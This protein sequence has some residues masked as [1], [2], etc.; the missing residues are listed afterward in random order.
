MRCLTSALRQMVARGWMYGKQTIQ[1][2]TTYVG[3]KGDTDVQGS[4]TQTK[5][6]DPCGNHSISI[7][8][9]GSLTLVYSEV[10]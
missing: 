3:K 2:Q 6:E 4:C 5:N 7:A 8:N 10:Q 9:S 1:L